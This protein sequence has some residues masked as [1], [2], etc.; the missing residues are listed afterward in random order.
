MLSKVERRK[1]FPPLPTLL[2]IALVFSVG[3]EYFFADD[4]KRRWRR[5]LVGIAR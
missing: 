1:P 5:V 4:Q 3:L 2:R